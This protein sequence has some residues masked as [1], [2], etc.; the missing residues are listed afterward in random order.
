MICPTGETEYF[1]GKDW[2]GGISLNCFN[3]FDFTRRRR[4][5][6]FTTPIISSIAPS[7]QPRQSRP[8][9]KMPAPGTTGELPST[10]TKRR[11]ATHLQPTAA[12]RRETTEMKDGLVLLGGR[13]VAP[14]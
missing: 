10:E 7:L 11:S 1:C 8:S 3:K 5:P 14:T 2:T 12:E 4:G 6:D 9:G 13:A